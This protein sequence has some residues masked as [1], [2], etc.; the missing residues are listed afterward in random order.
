MVIGPWADLEAMQELLRG[1]LQYTPM[2]NVFF[3]NNVSVCSAFPLSVLLYLHVLC[4][5]DLQ[6]TLLGPSHLAASIA[7]PLWL[8]CGGTLRA[9][10]KHDP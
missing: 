4:L 10:V 6:A 3:C 9:C 7:R 2:S 5:I 1:V 8:I